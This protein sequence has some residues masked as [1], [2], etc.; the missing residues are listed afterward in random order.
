MAENSFFIT[1][2]GPCGGFSPLVRVH[3]I[4]FFGLSAVFWHHA[5]VI[6]KLPNWQQQILKFM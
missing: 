3:A 1:L 6:C 2:R 5:R 4:P